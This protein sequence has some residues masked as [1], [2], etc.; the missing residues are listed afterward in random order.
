MSQMEPFTLFI[1]IMISLLAG[2]GIEGARQGRRRKKHILMKDAI[3]TRGLRS[4]SAE[5]SVF[6]VF[7]DLGASEF[8]IEVM[9]SQRFL[10]DDPQSVEVALD[11]I[12]DAIDTHGSYETFIRENLEAI[13]E[14]FEEHRHAG[15][16]RALP[17]LEQRQGKTLE[18]PA[19]GYETGTKAI[20]TQERRLDM[21][22]LDQGMNVEIDIDAM[23][24]VD[25]IAMVKSVL[26]GDA[27]ELEK[28]WQRRSL[29]GLRDELDS[30]LRD[31][32]AAY[33]GMLMRD[34]AS[35]RH[36][37]DVADRWNFEAQRI[38]DLRNRKIFRLRPF[39][40]C[41]EAL[42]SEGTAVAR[43]LSY[44]ARSN[45]EQTIEMIHHHAMTGNTSMAGYLIFLNRHAFF[46]G[47]LEHVRDLVQRIENTTYRLQNQMR[48]DL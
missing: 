32:Y 15:H 13:E 19:I 10:P 47:R 21:P 28:W 39:R 37:Y 14:M 38:E 31:L 40:S 48:Q 36:L 42:L 7:W 27:K 44:R 1:I 4:R 5:A 18:L 6:D 24:R 33:K 20:S 2:G 25:P 22:L 12:Q 23:L 45:V 41:A 9:A 11:Q 26:F 16:R 46:A 29:R 34:P 30:H 8:A 35:L 17:L 3:R 43:Q